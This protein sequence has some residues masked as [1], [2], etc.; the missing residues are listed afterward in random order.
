MSSL[1]R[2]EQMLVAVV[3]LAFCAGLGVKQWRESRALAPLQ[4]GAQIGR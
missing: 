3:L 1:T 2:R 4:A